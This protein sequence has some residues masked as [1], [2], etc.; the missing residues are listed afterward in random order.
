MNAPTDEELREILEAVEQYGQSGAARHLG[1]PR[2]TLRN[3]RKLAARRFGQGQ[4]PDVE[5]PVFPDEDIPIEQVIDQMERRFEKRHS[6]HHA[7]Q[8]FPIKFKTDDPIG[9]LWVGD[10]HADDDGCHWPLLRKHTALC[11]DTD[12]MYAVCIGD[13]SNNWHGR[14]TAL[15]A[16]QDTSADTARRLVEW[17]L[18]ESGIDW[19][20]IILGNHDS[21][22]DGA[23]ILSQMVKRG[24]KELRCHDWE[25]RFRLVF[26]NEWS[27]QIFASHDFKGHSMWNPMHGPLKAGMMGPTADVYV[28][29]HK[30]NWGTYTFENAAR[31]REQH[32]IRVRGYKFL[33][34]YGRRLGITE[35]Q[36]GA[37]V[38]TV[39]DP[40][41][42]SITTFSDV[43][44]GAEFLTSIRSA[45]H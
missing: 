2:S 13:L 31:G 14:L 38:L 34:E 12:G 35:Q 16:R 10:P 33:D 9:I 24:A 25:A 1:I 3:R 7:R 5:L 11:R 4:A 27:P 22:G 32:F 28:C 26:P 29:G 8:W 18:L 17:L 19:I 45:K 21:W 39:F 42:E 41:R 15:W 30:H 36:G 43:D 23:A 40:T 37:S 44:R 6:H 20:V